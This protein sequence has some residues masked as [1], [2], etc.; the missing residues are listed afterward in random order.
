MNP[1]NKPQGCM[2]I[3]FECAYTDNGTRIHYDGTFLYDRETLTGTFERPDAKGSFLFKKV[4]VSYILCLRPLTTQLDAKE[5]W[6]FAYNAVVEN[7][8][9]QNPR[10]SYLCGRMTK[11]R[12]VIGFMYKDDLNLLDEVQQ[13]EYSGLR[14]SFSFEEMTE[15]YKLYLWYDRSAN[16]QP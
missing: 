2:G 12:Q 14:K 10:L 13:V 11:M 7:I 9:R 8:R 5:L 16:L 3:N 6:S 15:L 4:P 1:I